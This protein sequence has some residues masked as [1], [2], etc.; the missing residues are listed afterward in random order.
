LLLIASLGVLGAILGAAWW[1]LGIVRDALREVAR[2]EI[3]AALPQL[4]WGLVRRAANDLPTSERE[5][6]EEWEHRLEGVAGRPILMLMLAMNIYRTRKA[7][8]AELLQPATEPAGRRAKRPR[9]QPPSASGILV[10]IVTTAQWARENMWPVATLGFGLVGP[11]VAEMSS[12]TRHLALPFL[13][14]NAFI[15]LIAAIY[16]LVRSRR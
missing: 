16:L 8:A 7:L 10:G 11:F 3:K 5:I 4:A 15:A 12:A 1:L 14:L 9:R 6:A 13:A 2:D